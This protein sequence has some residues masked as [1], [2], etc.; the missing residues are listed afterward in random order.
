M[1]DGAG[2]EA[3]GAAGGVEHVFVEL[4]VDH[5]DHELGDGAGSVEF[6]GVACALQVFEQ[7]LVDVVEGVAV[8]GA[9]E[10]DLVEFVDDLAHEGAVFHVVEGIF[11]RALH[12]EGARA[13]AFFGGEFFEGWKEFVVDEVLQGIAGDA[14]G[15]RRPVAPAQFFRDGRFEFVFGE[16][17][18]L[19]LVVEDFEE[20]H[21][22]E[23]ADALGVAVDASVF[24]HD[25]LDGF[26][27]G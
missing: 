22:S 6:A 10:V 18:F 12:D 19:F 20:Q 13:G 14:F 26:D 24:A 1:F 2:E 25:V 5:V 27:G 9:V 3:A 17:E 15:V 21:P 7:F 23:L 16:F 8:R 4:G 11:K